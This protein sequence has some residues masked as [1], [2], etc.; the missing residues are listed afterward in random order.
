MAH[1]EYVPQILVEGGTSAMTNLERLDDPHRAVGSEVLAAECVEQI[2]AAD[3]ALP[4]A[5]I[6]IVVCSEQL[7]FRENGSSG[8]HNVFGGFSIKSEFLS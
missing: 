3:S 6:P 7:V 4:N 2:P 5:A 8:S 1:C